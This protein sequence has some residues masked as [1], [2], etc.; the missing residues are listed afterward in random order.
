MPEEE[1]AGLWWGPRGVWTAIQPQVPKAV[2]PDG[3]G[4][5]IRH[6]GAERG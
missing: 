1:A 3:D 4:K 5:E 2:G 6:Q